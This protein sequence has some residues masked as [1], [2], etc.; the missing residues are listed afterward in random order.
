M[1]AAVPLGRVA[2]A[3]EMA[4]VVGFLCS[5]DASY[6]GGQVIVAGGGRSLS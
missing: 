6:L 2:R 4:A 3:E 5:K 1:V